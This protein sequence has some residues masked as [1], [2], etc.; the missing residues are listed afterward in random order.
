MKDHKMNFATSTLT[1]SR[2]F[3]KKAME[4]PNSKECQIIEHCRSLCPNLKIAYYTRKSSNN[5]AYSGLTY[6]KMEDYIKLYEN[7]QELLKIF[8]LIKAASKIQKNKFGYVYNWFIKQFPDYEELP[9]IKN[10]KLYVPVIVTP[11]INEN[12][13]A[14]AS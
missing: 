2:D 9:K 6:R 8:A 1:I 13:L 10:G 12:A 14:M 4:Y 7:S 5:K 11:E 3:A